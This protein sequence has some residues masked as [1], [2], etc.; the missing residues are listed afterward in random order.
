LQKGK[1]QRMMSRK[2]QTQNNADIGTGYFLRFTPEEQK[3]VF[4]FLTINGHEDSPEGIKNF[5]LNCIREPD[6]VNKGD[7]LSSITAILEDHP[8]IVQG[9]IEKVGSFIRKKIWGTKKKGT[10]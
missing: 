1:G 6:P 5:I 7:A 4:D 10:P 8:E 9:G 2:K 3:E